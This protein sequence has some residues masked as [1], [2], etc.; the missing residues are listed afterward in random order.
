MAVLHRCIVCESLTA[1]PIE[2][3]RYRCPT[4]GA[5]FTDGFR[6]L[7]EDMGVSS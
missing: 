5:V 6:R 1:Q 2:G 3:D 4:C 7:V